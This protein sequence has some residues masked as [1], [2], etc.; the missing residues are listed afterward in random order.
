MRVAIAAADHRG[1]GARGNE[2]GSSNVLGAGRAR[3]IARDCSLDCSR[4]R[5]CGSAKEKFCHGRPGL[6]GFSKT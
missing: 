6:T 5:A 2:R 4:A 3:C 1:K